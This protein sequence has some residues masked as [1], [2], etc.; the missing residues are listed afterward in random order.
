MKMTFICGSNSR[1]LSTN[2]ATP[3]RTT[4]AAS[5]EERSQMALQKRR[6]ETLNWIAARFRLLAQQPD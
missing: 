2:R 4:C 3:L 1:I 5:I 6:L